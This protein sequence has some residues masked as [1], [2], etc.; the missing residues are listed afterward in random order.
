MLPL[1]LQ[2]IQRI[3]YNTSGVYF[4]YLCDSGGNKVF[5][6]RLCKTDEDGVVYIGAAEKTTITYRLTNFLHSMNPDRKQNNHSA[7]KKINDNIT[8]K[9]WLSSFSLYFD[10]ISTPNA[11]NLEFD[12]LIKYKS[13]F[14]ELPPLNG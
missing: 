14:G 10:I 1:T 6:N 5:I 8:L 7:G 13:E 2:N 3:Q 12:Y 9:K 4:I 11:K